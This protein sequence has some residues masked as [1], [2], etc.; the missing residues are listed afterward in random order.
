MRRT[1]TIS[2]SLALIAAI[3]IPGLGG[4]TIKVYT[5]K[6]PP[7]LDINAVVTRIREQSFDVTVTLNTQTMSPDLS[8]CGST[9]PTVAGWTERRYDSVLAMRTRIESRTYE[10]NFADGSC[11]AGERYPSITLKPKSKAL[12]I[13][14]LQV[15]R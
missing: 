9:P 3:F 7:E 5:T 2:F 4:K 15:A 12:S 14:D 10:L 1:L 6:A 13:W 8:F 11:T